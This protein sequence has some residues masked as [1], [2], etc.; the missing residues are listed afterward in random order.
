MNVRFA[1]LGAVVGTIVFLWPARDGLFGDPNGEVHNHL[2]FFAHTLLGLQANAPAG[3]D[4]PLMDPPNLPWFALGWLG[5]PTLA[6][7]VTAVANVLLAC[8]GGWVLGREVTGRPI[9]AL[10]A[11]AS[12][13]WSPFL[14]GAIEFGVSEAWPLGWYALHLAA[15]VRLRTDVRPRVWLAAGVT[16]GVFALSGWYHAAFALVVAPLVAL[17]IRRR[18]VFW[19]GAIALAMVLPRLWDLVPHLGVWSDRAAGL[20]D[21][22][23]IRQWQKQERYGIDLLRFFP[24]T[25]RFT[26]SYSVYLGSIAV[27]LGILG[28]RRAWVWLAM[29]APLWVLALGHWLRIGGNVVVEVPLPA[30]WLVQGLDSARFVTHWYR[31]SG[32][33]TVL[34]GAAA[35]W[36]AVAVER[37]FSV[38]FFGPTD[39]RATADARATSS[40]SARR[41][42]WLLAGSGPLLLALIL[43]D[44]LALSST[45]WPRV[46]APLPLPPDLPLSG[47]VL[48]LPVDDNRTRPEVF[49]TRRP[50]WMWQLT[51]RQPVAENHEAAD[52]VLA[53]SGEA[54]ALQLACGGLPRA[55][56]GAGA[57][58]EILPGSEDVGLKELGFTAVVVHAQLAPDGCAA[59]VEARFGAAMADAEG[60][61][62]FGVR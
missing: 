38:W 9:G 26:P 22:T 43:V 41:G 23:N 19:A 62:M 30:G 53:A 47:A 31:A 58:G 42:R 48:D 4:V 51:H 3:W 15:M 49:G 16:L 10:V 54:R 13:G 11:M 37:R 24:S 21:P 46:A 56:P 33:A 20:S 60:A 36:G 25:D 6:W 7:N 8:F 17:H 29:A 35:A 59:A 14:G 50:Y 40:G 5:S 45:R 2:W 28:G 61:R 18:A 32:P 27:T 1:G 12:I 55:R 52:S 57:A 44:S 39:A 34:L